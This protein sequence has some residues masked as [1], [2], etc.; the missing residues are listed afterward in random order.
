MRV[1]S[2]PK[3]VGSWR[4]TV[5]LLLGSH[6]LHWWSIDASEH[7]SPTALAAIDRADE[8]AVAA[9]SWFELAW[10]AHHRR[11]LVRIPIHSWLEALAKRVHALAITPAIADMA[12]ALPPAF[13]ATPPIA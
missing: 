10:L 2:E 4:R 8:L 11:I 3:R 9:I 12:V 6:V 7:F 13:R 1:C 5:T